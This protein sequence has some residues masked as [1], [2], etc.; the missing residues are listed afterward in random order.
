MN[1][2]PGVA[3]FSTTNT[4]VE[5][6]QVRSEQQILNS[7]V[8]APARWKK[9][10]QGFIKCNIDAA[11]SQSS[12]SMSVGVCIRNELGE[13]LRATA[14]NFK[15]LLEVKVGEALGLLVVIRGRSRTK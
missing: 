1:G 15:Q 14:F 6:L 5:W 8:E 7:S 12:N 9:S 2:R 4:L 11:F 13:F 10:E 3:I